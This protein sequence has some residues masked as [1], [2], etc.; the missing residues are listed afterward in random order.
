MSDHSI[1]NS[2]LFQLDMC[3]QL[4]QYHMNTLEET[5]AYW[6]ASPTGLKVSKQDGKW[7]ADWPE[8]ESYDIGPAS[9]AWIMWHM[10]YWWSTA[11]EGNFGDGILEKDDIVWPGSIDKAKETIAALHNKWVSNLNELSDSD[12][13]SKQHAKWPLADNSFTDIALW[14]NG[15]LMKNT[16]EIGYGRFLYAASAKQGTQA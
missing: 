10:I 5:E 6:T 12:Y 13:H 8:T 9:I 1:K 2:I 16:A 7:T 14:L 3:W 11:L 4:Y 15:E